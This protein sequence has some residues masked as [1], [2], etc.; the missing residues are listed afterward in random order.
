MCLYV[1]TECCMFTVVFMGAHYTWKSSLYVGDIT[2]EEKG[3]NI[4][5]HITN[6]G[7]QSLPA[8]KGDT[9]ASICT[10]S[11]KHCRSWCSGGKQ[12]QAASRCFLDPCV[13]TFQRSHC[14]GREWEHPQGWSWHVPFTTLDS[15]VARWLFQLP[16]S[17]TKIHC[18]TL[19]R[20]LTCHKQQLVAIGVGKEG[21]SRVLQPIDKLLLVLMRLRLGLFEQNLF[22]VLQCHNL[23]V[24]EYG[25]H[26]NACL[27][28][29]N[30][31]Y[32]CT[33]SFSWDNTG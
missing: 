33:R 13:L 20:Q 1:L 11:S 28:P 6:E 10:N 9:D 25:P 5:G 26:G 31:S 2:T 12:L 32:L 21:R 18:S 24:A 7:E 8:S 30:V 16:W 4:P 29:Y 23:Q 14:T 3:T 15:Q 27:H 17:C 22:T 19:R